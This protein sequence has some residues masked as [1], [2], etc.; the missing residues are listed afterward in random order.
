[1]GL[2]EAEDMTQLHNVWLVTKFGMGL[3]VAVKWV[4]Q[5]GKASGTDL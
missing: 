2:N 3:W 5:L 4:K 1:M